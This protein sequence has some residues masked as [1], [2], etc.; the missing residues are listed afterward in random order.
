MEPV[1]NEGSMSL[2]KTLQVLHSQVIRSQ[3]FATARQPSP[4]AE[5]GSLDELLAI[6]S[7]ERDDLAS[8]DT[9]TGALLVEHRARPQAWGP[10]LALAFAP[11]L[12]AHAHER[13]RHRRN[14]LD[15]VLL[16]AFFEAVAAC[17][18]SDANAHAFVVEELKQRVSRAFSGRVEAQL[19]AG[20]LDRLESDGA[21][22]LWASPR[23]CRERA[24]RKQREDLKAESGELCALLRREVGKRIPAAQVELVC[25]T[26]LSGTSLTDL[27]ASRL[28]RTT[29]HARTLEYKRLYRL[30]TRAL[31][32]LAELLGFDDEPR[33]E[34]VEERWAPL[35]REALKASR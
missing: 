22:D 29:E 8:L 5:V 9:L 7:G 33:P 4:L 16:T 12:E 32:D 28:P 24:L 25:T 3:V 14:D 19:E 34:T 13:R 21:E 15:G 17:S 23:L 6:F 1:S 30:R 31:E 11:T 27:V 10:V 26:L 18:P 35:L 20:A 2:S